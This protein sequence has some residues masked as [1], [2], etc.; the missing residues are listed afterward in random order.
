[1]S[2]CFTMFHLRTRAFPHQVCRGRVYAASIAE[3][4][5]IRVVVSPVPLVPLVSAAAALGEIHRQLLPLPVAGVRHHGPGFAMAWMSVCWGR[6]RSGHRLR[7]R[8]PVA[9]RTWFLVRTHVFFFSF[10]GDSG[11]SAHFFGVSFCA[12]SH[13]LHALIPSF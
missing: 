8:R 3:R 9:V 11:D 13:G 1:M 5:V 2:P 4:G 10:S 7:F 12:P 6:N